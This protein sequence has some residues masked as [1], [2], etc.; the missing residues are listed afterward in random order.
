MPED[1]PQ[2]YFINNYCKHDLDN[3]DYLLP[4]ESSCFILSLHLLK[5]CLPNNFVSCLSLTNTF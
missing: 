4:L 2:V 1:I 5:S 3:C